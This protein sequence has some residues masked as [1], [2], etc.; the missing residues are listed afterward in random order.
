MED[1]AMCRAVKVMCVAEDDASLSLLKRAAVSAGWEL[2][3]GATDEREALDQI[4]AERPHVLVVFGAFPL[5]RGLVAERFPGMRVVSD[6]P[7]DAVT[8]VAQNLDEVRLLVS[9]MPRPGGPV[10]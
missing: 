5:L 7:A 4:D 1:G 2:T 9:G 10:G 3:P 8:A 6:R